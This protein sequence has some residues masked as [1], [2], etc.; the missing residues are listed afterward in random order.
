[1]TWYKQ[2]LSSITLSF[3][4]FIIF[5]LMSGCASDN[6]LREQQTLNRRLSQLATKQDILAREQQKLKADTNIKLDN[7]DREM[8]LLRQ[9]VEDNLAK[10]EE[11]GTTSPTPA[12]LQKTLAQI[13]ERLSKLEQG[14]AATPKPT[15]PN[16]PPQASPNSTPPH[17][18][19]KL[20]GAREKAAYDAAYSTFKRGD[21][22]TA[23]KKFRKFISTYPHSNYKANALFW[24]AECYYKTGDYAEAI[25]KYD[26]IV[27]SY[28]KHPKAASA[29]LKQGFAFIQLNDTT[30]GKLILEKVLRQYPGSDQA[31][32]AQRKL[33]LLK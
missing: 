14:V 26:E 6:Q 18:I 25:I 4:I 10:P 32:I 3:I 27:T 19:K 5:L 16:T 20:P 1:M 22:K 7:L 33:K 11:L 9:A 21:Y 23:R 17:T 24:I 15:S 2:G 30:D 13:E 31:R 28:P 29:L 8:G 12:E